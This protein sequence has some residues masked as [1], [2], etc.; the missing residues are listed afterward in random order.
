MLVV[1]GTLRGTLHGLLRNSMG[2]WRGACEKEASNR[3]TCITGPS[4][5]LDLNPKSTIHGPEFF[6]GKEHRSIN[7]DEAVEYIAAVQDAV[8]TGEGSSQ[9][10]DCCIGRDSFDHGCGDCGGVTT[11]LIERNT[12]IPTKTAQTLATHADNQPRALIQIVE[13]ERR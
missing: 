11:K 9:V 5:R 1:A 13:G 7:P 12:T 10:Q 2:S 4:G 6:N 3:R 8:H